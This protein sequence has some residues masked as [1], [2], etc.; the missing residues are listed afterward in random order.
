MVAEETLLGA[1]FD[2]T[3]PMKVRTARA[4]R[5]DRRR[6]P[7]DETNRHDDATPCPDRLGGRQRGQPQAGPRVLQSNPR[8]I[9]RT[10]RATETDRKEGQRNPNLPK[11]GPGTTLEGNKAHG[12]IGRSNAGNGGGTQR[13]RRWSKA[14]EP[15]AHAMRPTVPGNGDVPGNGVVPGNGD[16]PRKRRQV[17]SRTERRKLP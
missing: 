14:L 1:F 11:S 13:T 8:G 2:V 15:T 16:R 4:E 10:G 12:R 9:R 5:V 6:K 3:N 17:A 7:E